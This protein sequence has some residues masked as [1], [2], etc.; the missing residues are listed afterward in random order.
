MLPLHSKIF[1]DHIIYLKYSLGSLYFVTNQRKYKLFEQLFVLF[2][3]ALLNTI[4]LILSQ[5]RIM[6][7]ASENKHFMK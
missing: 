1:I 6:I 5:D 7:V 4:A 2:G 3:F